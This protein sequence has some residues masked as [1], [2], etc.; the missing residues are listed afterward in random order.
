[1]DAKREKQFES[2]GV[3]WNNKEMESSDDEHFDQNFDLLVI[4]NE[5]EGHVRV[6]VE[7]QES[8]TDN[9]GIWL[10]NQQSLHRIG[11]LQFDRQKWLEVVGVTWDTDTT[12]NVSSA[13]MS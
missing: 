10:G 5:R 1:M 11:A 8:I 6:P 12:A 13:C 7:H 3:K 9:L 4:F 2:L